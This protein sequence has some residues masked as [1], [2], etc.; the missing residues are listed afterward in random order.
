MP[1]GQTHRRRACDHQR[2]SD[3]MSGNNLELLKELT[4][5][6]FSRVLPRLYM[7]TRRQPELRASVINEKNIVS[8]NDG[9]V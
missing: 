1:S 3:L 4:P 7:A 5:H 6:G 8:V 2:L 9:K